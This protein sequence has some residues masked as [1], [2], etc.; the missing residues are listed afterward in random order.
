M[1]EFADYR[2]QMNEGKILP[3]HVVNVLLDRLTLLLY[4]ES[5]VVVVQSPVIICGNIHGQYEDL[6]ELFRLCDPSKDR[7]VFMGDYVDRG[8][9]SLNTFL[10]LVTY[11]LQYPSQ[12]YLLRGNHES[13]QVTQQYGFQQEILASYG[14]T[15]LWVK[16]MD[17]FDL[18]PY[19]SLVDGDVFSVHGGLSPRM[20]LI[21][22][23]EKV[24][25]RVEIPTEGLL[26]DLA[27]S[28]PDDVGVKDYRPNQRG[29]GW[30]F[31]Q[32][33]VKRF[34]QQNKLQLVTR[35]HQLVQSGFQ[36][37]FAEEGDITPGKLINVWSAPNYAYTSKNIASILK[38][39]FNNNPRSFETPTFDEA[40]KRIP[41][42]SVKPTMDYFA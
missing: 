33:A 17:V 40:Q 36:W 6:Q 31:G 7:F 18:L 3:E 20:P 41:P 15:S 26:A 29:A 37:Y 16:A 21:G 5:N 4:N 12:Y 25:R 14:H 8:K 34:C 24:D 2:K 1:G 23:A 27:W 10:L 9:Y 22:L 13:R 28:D 32:L 19:A 38:V 39:R 35:S 30:I 42:D 11:K